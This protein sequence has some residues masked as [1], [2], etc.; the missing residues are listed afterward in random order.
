[1]EVVEVEEEACSG[2]VVVDST[3]V[4]GTTSKTK[5]F[6]SNVAGPFFPQDL[7]M[8]FIT[9]WLQFTQVPVEFLNTPDE[10]KLQ[11]ENV[12]P[13]HSGQESNICFASV[14]VCTGTDDR[15]NPFGRNPLPT[16]S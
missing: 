10:S 1:V 8:K 2:D 7:T 11:H 3:S 15:R 16:A 14:P 4:Y 5:R 6:N 13:S 9:V 12:A